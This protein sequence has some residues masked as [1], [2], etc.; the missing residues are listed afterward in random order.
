MQGPYFICVVC[1]RTSYRQMFIQ[2]CEE[3]YV[4]EDPN[5]YFARIESFDGLEYICKTCHR[6]LQSKGDKTPCQAVCNKL[7]LYELPTELADINKLERV[8]IAKRLLF[9]KIVIMPKGQYPKVK[10]AI[11]NVP[12]DVENVC[13]VL[14]R[15]PD[16][17]G[18]LFLKLKRKL[19]YQGHVYFEAVRPEKMHAALHYLKGNNHLYYDAEINVDH[20]PRELCFVDDDNP[21][22]DL[23]INE[24]CEKV[25]TLMP[26]RVKMRK[27]LG[28]N[29]YKIHTELPAMKQQCS[30]ISQLNLTL[31][32]YLLLQ[33][34]VSHLF[35]FLVINFVKKWHFLIC[36]RPENLVIKL[37]VM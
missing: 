16:N 11:C 15:P 19:M 6:K 29:I 18:L 23:I 13:K 1:N 9:K 34:K 21:D 7:D 35:Q 20:V 24:N 2:F 12:V 17:N 5:F 26:L 14:P 8:L 27:I 10:G 3:K 25:L 31:I 22:I 30:Q 36:F 32:L 37:I 33:V 4:I 28:M